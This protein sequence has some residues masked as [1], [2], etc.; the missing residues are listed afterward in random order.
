MARDQGCA[1]VTGGT[2]F[3][4]ANLVRLLLDEGWSVRALAR[5]GSDTRNLDGLDIELVRGAVTDPDLDRRMHGCRAVFHV[6]AQYSLLRSDRESVLRSNVEGTRNILTAARKA[7]V[8]R[9]V[10]TSSV[11]AIGVRHEG[12]ADEAYQAPLEATIGAYKR[13]KHLAEEEARAAA[14]GQEVVIVNPS[15]PLGAW[16]RKPTPTGDILVRFMTDRMPVIVETGLNFVDVTDVARG[17]LLAFERGR[18]GERYILGAENLSL[19][20][21]LER[22]G[23]VAG[24]SAP[25]WGVPHWIPLAAAFVEERVLAPLGSRPPT[26]SVDGVR[27]SR[28]FMYY[29]TSK[30]TRELGYSPAPIDG[31]V[32]SALEWFAANGYFS[33][34]G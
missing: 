10:Y 3:V 22:V 26:L 12:P 32:R 27:M 33:K 8:E 29:D 17:H 30:A 11:S 28:E 34:R 7:G 5:D 1:F 9:T 19:R 4:G 21:L 2:G 16:D 18:R 31:A 15:T 14:A 23:A 13:S 6:A 24:K 25:R 20:T